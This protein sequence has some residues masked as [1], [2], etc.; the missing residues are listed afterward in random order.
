M[1]DSHEV[2]VLGVKAAGDAAHCRRPATVL[3]P[4]EFDL[5]LFRLQRLKR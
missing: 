3:S 2:V 1:R 4:T 5:S